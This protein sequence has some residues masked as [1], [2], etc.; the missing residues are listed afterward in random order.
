MKLVNLY[1]GAVVYLLRGRKTFLIPVL[2]NNY[3]TAALKLLEKLYKVSIERSQWGEG[4]IDGRV[5]CSTEVVCGKPF[6]SCLGFNC[7]HLVLHQVN[8]KVKHVEYDT[9]YIPEISSLVD[10]QED[11]LMW[12]LHQAGMVRIH[13]KHILKALVFSQSTNKDKKSPIWA[14][15]FVLDFG[16]NVTV[17]WLALHSWNFWSVWDIINGQ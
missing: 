13:L 8:L 9:F 14:V 15:Q 16:V 1:K 7:P 10:I 3:I 11:Y 4:W 17:F 5:K 2:F 12:F 6:S